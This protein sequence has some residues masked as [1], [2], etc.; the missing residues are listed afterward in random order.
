MIDQWRRTY[1]EIRPHEALG[2]LTPAQCYRASERGYI[3]V[4]PVLEYPLGFE[5]RKVLHNGQIVYNGLRVS[6]STALEGSTVGLQPLDDG[7]FRVWLADFYLGVLDLK[8][9]CFTA[10]VDVESEGKPDEM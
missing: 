6:L 1:N 8:N 9:C 7:S 2:M 10:D 4:V 5:A 3:D